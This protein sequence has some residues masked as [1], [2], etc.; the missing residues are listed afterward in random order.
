MLKNKDGTPYKLSSPNPLVKDQLWQELVLHNWNWN[1]IDTDIAKPEPIQ[2]TPEPEPEL[3]PEPEPELAP[4]ELEPEPELAPEELVPEPEEEFI[5]IISSL[6]GERKLLKNM[7]L[8]HC[9]PKTGKKF[10][11]EAVIL[12]R[13]D[14]GIIFWAPIQIETGS[15]I[16]PSVYIDGN[17]SYGDFQWWKVDK[18]EP[19]NQGFL[20]SGMISDIQPDFS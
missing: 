5:P 14:F 16:Y 19:K 10:S 17:R 13:G 20:I 8:V 18:T 7:V 9:L 11:F 15:I 3:V 2:P 4:E 6:K 12:K 1:Y